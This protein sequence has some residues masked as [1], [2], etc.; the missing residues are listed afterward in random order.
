MAVPRKSSLPNLLSAARMLL[1]PTALIAALAASKLWFTALLAAAL[2]TDALDGLLARWL[3][4][5]TDF[6]RKLDSAADYLTLLTGLAGIAVLWPDIMHRELHWVAAGLTMFFA[7]IVL[8]FVRLGR[9]PCYHTWVAK[10][11]AVACALSLVPLLADRTARPFHAAMILQ[12][13]GGAEEMAILLLVPW[14]TGAVHT[15]W[16]ALKLRR[17]GA[18]AG[19]G[20]AGQSG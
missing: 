7:V 18:P 1:M 8:G 11:A 14:H 20:A 12:I 3:H 5:E 2:A 13:A 4:A 15:V 16:Q 10:A 17:K 9:A 19:A 6:G